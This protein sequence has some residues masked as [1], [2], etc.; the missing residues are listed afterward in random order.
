MLLA[1]HQGGAA[2]IGDVVFNRCAITSANFFPQVWVGAPQTDAMTGLVDK[3]AQ[4]YTVIRNLSIAMLL[5]ILLYVGIRMAISTVAPDKA[6]YQ[7]MLYNWVI[8]LVLVF[9]LHYIMIIVFFINNLIV[10]ALSQAD[11]T[12]T[13]DMVYLAAEAAVPF[14]GMDELIVYGALVVGTLMFVLTYI[15]RTIV[16][17]F[18]I[19]IA[20][21]ITITYSID[22]MGDGK[23]QALNT[24]LREFIFTVIVQPFHCVIYLVFYASTMTVLGASGAFDLGKAIFA[25]A[26]AFFMLK[27]EGIVKKI[28]GIQPS[29]IGDA[30]GTGAMVLTGAANLFKGKGKKINEGKGTMDKMQ[31][32]ISKKDEQSGKGN[33]NEKGANATQTAGNTSGAGN[34]NG[35]EGN[36]SSSGEGTEGSNSSE[37]S[38]EGNGAEGGASNAASQGNESQAGNT[39]REK[40]P[41]KIKSAIGAA[42]YNLVTK[43]IKRQGGLQNYVGRKISGAATLAGFIAGAS[44]GEF[45]T[46]VSVGT[47][48]SSLAS[49]KYDDVIYKRTERQLEENQK[50]FAGAYEDFARAYRDEHGADIDEQQ[51]RAAAKHIYDGGGQNLQTE[52]ER[53]FYSQMEQLAGGAE[54]MGYKD[55]FDYVNDSMRLVQDGIVT[56]NKDYVPK[57]YN[58]SAG[59]TSSSSTGTK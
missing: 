52:A 34:S 4:Y 9:V 12:E 35:S 50:V 37:S 27:A 51:I 57:F 33:K 36:N 59:R 8:S 49:Q 25:A 21:L 18:L 7:K 58:T 22:K 10:N 14:V 31:N 13:I 20:P 23:S 39:R 53:D 2:S 15:K 56:P 19:V 48:A 54:I 42:A 32:N 43:P 44:V 3:I 47:A 38:S 16:L 30:I 28:F 55:G 6:K 26:S 11:T 17:G 24:W 1:H 45:N 40:K 46:A 5:G 29:G 41:S